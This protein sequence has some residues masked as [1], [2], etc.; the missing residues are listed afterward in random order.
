MRDFVLHVENAEVFRIEVL[1]KRFNE[2]VKNES[3]P[4]ER[5]PWIRIW[6]PCIKIEHGN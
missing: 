3:K 4:I 2:A 5:R 1:P 6:N